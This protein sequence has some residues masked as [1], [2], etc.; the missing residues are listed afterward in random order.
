[1]EGTRDG[2]GWSRTFS[3]RAGRPAHPSFGSLDGLLPALQPHVV[4]SQQMRGNVFHSLTANAS[5][6]AEVP[7]E[8][9]A[10]CYSEA[11][12]VC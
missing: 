10:A 11:A 7:L 5:Q 9:S 1:M 8:L 12:G 6:V 4:L 3:P 2:R